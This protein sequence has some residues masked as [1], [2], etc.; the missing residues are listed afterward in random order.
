MAYSSFSQPCFSKKIGGNRSAY[1]EDSRSNQSTKVAP[2]E[3]LER[4][5]IAHLFQ[6]E[7]YASNGT[8]KCHADTCRRTR[9]Q[10]LP[11]LG[12]IPPVLVEEPTNHISRADSIVHAGSLLA[13]R[14]ARANR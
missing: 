8:S 12:R 4:K 3:R 14:Q 7:Q 10:D 6:A 1:S 9:T 11:S 13:N 2:P 5:L